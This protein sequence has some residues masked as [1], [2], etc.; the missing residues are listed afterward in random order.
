MGVVISLGATNDPAGLSGALIKRRPKDRKAQI[1][2]AAAETFSAM[3]YHAAS[4][5]AIAAKVGISAPALY[6]HYPNKYQMFAAV[7]G[8]LGQQLVDCTAF[9][10]EV[11]DRELAEDPAGVLDR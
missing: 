9:L 5:E 10:D 8:M 7:V 11:S 3:G 6:R 2:R 1:A 4:M